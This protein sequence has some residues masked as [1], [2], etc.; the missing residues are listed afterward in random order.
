MINIDLAQYPVLREYYERI[1]SLDNVK[2]AHE[3]MAANPDC[4]V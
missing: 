1:K 3:R 2:A 4:V